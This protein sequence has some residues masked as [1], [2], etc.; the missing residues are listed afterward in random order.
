MTERESTGPDAGETGSGGE[1]GS[2]G[3]IDTGVRAQAFAH[4]DTWIF[5]LDNTLY[6]HEAKVWPQV[7]ARITHFLTHMFGIDGMS[8]RALQKYYYHRY[9][10]SLKGLM[11]EHDIDPKTF[12]D[13]A[14]DIDLT[15]LLPDPE[16]GAAIAALPGRKLIMTN[17][18][19]AHA[20]NVAGKLGFYHHFEAAFGIEEAGFVPKPERAA[21]QRFFA[22]HGIEPTR[23][24]M[25]EDIAK[26]LVVPH[27]LGMQTVMVIPKT[28]DPFREIFEQTGIAAP[29][30]GHITDDLAGFLR[31]IASA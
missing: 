24:A 5:D 21:F 15:A 7:D 19:I 13:F 1:A 20:A 28:P 9:G 23:A 25:F 26:N 16:L 22:L 2:G 8:A 3:G 18:T 14:H 27:E 11:Q 12:L 10:T 30:I 29:Y 4:V 17:G 6:P 31:T